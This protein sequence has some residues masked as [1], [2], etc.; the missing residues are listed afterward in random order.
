MIYKV[1][2]CL[3][4]EYD[5][6]EAD[7]EEEAFLIASDA[8]MSGGSW[9]WR[10]ERND[11]EHIDLKALPSAQPEIIMCNDCKHGITDGITDGF[12]LCSKPYTERGNA[13]HRDDWFCADGERRTE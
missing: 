3:E 7:S 11:N 8:A 9:E 12:V 4:A 1:Y 5:D 10:A 6:I 2:V 13:I